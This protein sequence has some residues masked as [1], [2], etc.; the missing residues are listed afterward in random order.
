MNIVHSIEYL[1]DLENKKEQLEGCIDLLN[2]EI[3]NEKNTC[4]H[5]P[6]NL[7]VCGNFSNVDKKYY[8]LICGKVLDN[9]VLDDFEDIVD[10]E[11]YLTNFDITNDLECKIKFDFIQ[12]IALDL[13][14]EK[15]NMSVKELVDKMNKLIRGDCLLDRCVSLKRIN[16]IKS[17]CIL[18][19]SSYGLV[20]KIR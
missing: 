1:K 12:I 10:A 9:N 19:N 11:N 5:I 7:G 14:K 4:L 16:D 13:L 17:R 20:K 8:C 18:E 15:T 3:E 2:K 6:V